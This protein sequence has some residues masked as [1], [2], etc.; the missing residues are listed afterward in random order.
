M[1]GLEAAEFIHTFGDAHIYENHLDQVGEQLTRTL[2]A[3]R[4]WKLTTA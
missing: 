3:P 2:S 1:T 4:S